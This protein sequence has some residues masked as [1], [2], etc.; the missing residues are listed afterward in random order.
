MVQSIS[1]IPG[2]HPAALADLLILE[3][4][5][6]LEPEQELVALVEISDEHVQDPGC[7]H[8]AQ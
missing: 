8:L 7:F 6:I 4:L 1:H 5:E 2:T 3:S